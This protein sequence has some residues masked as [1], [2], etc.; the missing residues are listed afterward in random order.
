MLEKKLIT[1][2]IYLMTPIELDIYVPLILNDIDFLAKDT[3]GNHMYS[4]ALK[5]FRMY[6]KATEDILVDDLS[7]HICNYDKITET[8]KKQLVKARI[9]QGD[10]RDKIIAKY[11]SKC[12]VTGISDQRLLVASHIKPWAV[13]NNTERLSAENGLLL[14]PL[15]DKLFDCGLMTFSKDGRLHLSSRLNPQ[16]ISKFKLPRCS[17][18][19]LKV[20]S[21]LAINLE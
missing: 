4:S 7:V 21:D 9:G 3:K 15:Y 13:C 2:S 8:E 19:D 14:S 11:D 10:F 17:Y 16:D 18:F 6:R 1:E 12:I 5:H 20:S